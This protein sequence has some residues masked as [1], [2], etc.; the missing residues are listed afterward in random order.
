MNVD[1]EE[2]MVMQAHSQ[3]MQTEF[4]FV[5]TFDENK[6]LE[7]QIRKDW[8][9]ESLPETERRFDKGSNLQSRMIHPCRTHLRHTQPTT[10][11]QFAR[12]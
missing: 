1:T 6:S 11:N 5:L 2:R 8:N 10:E 3:I 7:A 4:H 9:I 12:Q